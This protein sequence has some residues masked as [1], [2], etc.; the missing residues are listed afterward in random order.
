MLGAMGVRGWTALALVAAVGCSSGSGAGTGSTGSGD[1]STPQG[2]CD[3]TFGKFVDEIEASCTAADKQTDAGTL[4]FG[5]MQV[6]VMQCPSELS[7]SIAAGRASIDGNAAAQCIAAYD[8]IIDQISLGNTQNLGV[9]PGVLA[10][11]QAVVI[12]KQAIGAPCSQPYE[13]PAGASCVGQTGSTDGT[14]RTPAIG[15]TCGAG[16]SASGEITI[17]LTFGNHPECAS[18]AFCDTV[19]ENDEFVDRCV[20]LKAD[21]EDCSDPDECAIGGCHL[22]KCSGAGPSAQGMECLFGDDCADG[23]YCDDS[24]TTSVCAPKK[25]SGSA[26]SGG[27]LSDECAGTCNVPEGVSDGTCVAF[28]GQ[29]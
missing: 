10:A 1:P 22:G 14:C 27:L 25:P 9:D 8:E 20:A 5:L 4:L 24:G 21:G 26:C 28:C 13:C 2:L 17:T 16:E 11:C 19:Y 23:L 6:L 12:G 3:G 7:A 29:G 18:G 15:E